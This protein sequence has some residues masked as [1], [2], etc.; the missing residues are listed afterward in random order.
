[1]SYF[2]SCVLLCGI[3]SSES[4]VPPST[5]V[6]LVLEDTVGE[7][8]GDEGGGDDEVVDEV[9]E[10]HVGEGWADG[11][12]GLGFASGG[13]VFGGYSAVVGHGGRMESLLCWL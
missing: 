7:V 3:R 8:C 9:G 11:A 5:N 2:H 12:H 13:K 1:M 4:E 6:G 10:A